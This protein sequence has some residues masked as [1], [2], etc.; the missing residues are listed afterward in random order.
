MTQPTS[1]Y[2]IGNV[3][4]TPR[5][6]NEVMNDESGR[7][8]IHRHRSRCYWSFP[9][10]S[11]IEEDK[12]WKFDDFRRL[13]LP[14]WEYDPAE[15]AFM[16]TGSV[17]CLQEMFKV[18]IQN[19]ASEDKPFRFLIIGPFEIGTVPWFDFRRLISDLQAKFDLDHN[20]HSVLPEDP[21]LNSLEA[22]YE[23]EWRSEDL[24]FPTRAV[25]MTGATGFRRA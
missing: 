18:H 11:S 5:S 1:E 22:I 3:P 8:D 16:R 9:Y 19:N 15:Q 13:Q 10:K 25:E 21:S 17:E 12:R 14:I 23:K 6:A 4:A 24:P 7:N 20:D 2:Y